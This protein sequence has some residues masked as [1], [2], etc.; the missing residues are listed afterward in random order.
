M[1]AIQPWH[2]ILVLAIV[3][4]VVGPGKL[5]QVGKSVGD[6]IREFRHATTETLDATT[7]PPAPGQSSPAPLAPLAP[8]PPPPAAPA[9]EPPWVGP[10]Q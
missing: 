3:L 1:G 2:L 8:A 6:A 9:P 7:L 10:P 4:I 5:P